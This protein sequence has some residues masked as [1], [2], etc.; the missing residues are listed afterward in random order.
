MRITALTATHLRMPLQAPTLWAL[1]RHSS[2]PRLLV[3]LETDEGIS[4]IGETYYIPD[5]DRLLAAVAEVLATV[6][7]LHTTAVRRR[8]DTLS[9]DYD[10][11]VPLG[12]RAAIE[13]A[14]LDAAGK[15]LGVPVS[16]LLGGAI[17]SEVEAAAYLFY[18]EAMPDG[19]GGEDSPE[20]IVARAEELVDAHGFRTLKLKGGVHGVEA[21]RAAL[22][23]LAARF[24][25]APL[26]WD[27]NAAWS[28]PEA[29]AA[30]D[31]LRRDGTWLEYLEDPVADLAGLAA[32]HRRVDV[33]LATNMCVVQFEQLAPAIE[34]RAVDV[35]L[36][37]PHYW[38]GLVECRRLMAV[39]EAFRLGVGLHSDNDLGVSTAA[40][41]HLAAASPELSF[42]IDLHTPEHADELLLEPI[43][44]RGGVLRVPTGPGLGIAVDP[45][46]VA[47]LR[48]R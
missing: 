27:P 30:V 24:P 45:E 41:L 3:H 6:D 33:P 21:E 8:L 28:V 47:R 14:C 12:L 44:C 17:R 34:M 5:A 16:A 48:E 38:G 39:C 10:T 26:R 36:A 11:I 4:G 2:I 9:G 43:V 7:P 22:R 37:D 46:A 18:R 1:G 23:A 13:M 42:A 20:A 25:G 19:R 35:V 40:R 15:A 32:V 31:G 29:L